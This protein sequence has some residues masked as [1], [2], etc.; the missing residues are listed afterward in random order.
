MDSSKKRDLP[1]NCKNQIL[2]LRK[3]VQMKAALLALTIL[4]GT[5]AGAAQLTLTTYVSGQVYQGKIGQTYL[6]SQSSQLVI[7]GEDETKGCIISK[8]LAENT[9]FNLLSLGELIG[10]NQVDLECTV[11]NGKASAVKIVFR[12]N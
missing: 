1:V 7:L 11:G 8:T 3:K 5:H 6:D 2:E 9:D 10:K 12:L 4:V